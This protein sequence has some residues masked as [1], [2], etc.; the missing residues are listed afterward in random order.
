MAGR[1]RVALLAITLA[2]ARG[3]G[4]R[5]YQGPAER[6]LLR[7]PVTLASR[8]ADELLT[9]RSSDRERDPD[10]ERGRFPM[11]IGLPTHALAGQIFESISRY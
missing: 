7:L 2:T 10:A 9:T 1:A 5:V 3:L 11:T 4:N 6:R 8:P